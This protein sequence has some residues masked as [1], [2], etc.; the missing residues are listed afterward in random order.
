MNINA[1]HLA[2]KHA[3]SLSDIEREAMGRR[4]FDLSRNYKGDLA[5]EKISSLYFNLLK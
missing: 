4:G 3:I 1:L 2:L 5:F